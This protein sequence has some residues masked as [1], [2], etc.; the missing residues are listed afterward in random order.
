MFK[1]Y[2][3]AE[4]TEIAR[5]YNELLKNLPKSQR[6]WRMYSEKKS[7]S[8][9]ENLLFVKDLLK[10][11]KV[12]ASDITIFCE[13]TRKHRVSVLAKR[14]FGKR[15]ALHVVPID[16]DTSPNRYL[17]ADFFNKKE[18][19]VLQFDL[20]ALKST[21]N[22][23]KYHELFREKITFLRSRGTKNQSKAIEEWWRM[24]LK[25]IDERHLR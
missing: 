22:Y 16:F 21:K 18:A 1:P 11:Q 14:L 23:K 8:T 12:T 17:G 6:I 10:K 15:K 5:F 9:L 19:R 3:R 25:A 4:A 13:S 2:R 7:L 24:K 20:W